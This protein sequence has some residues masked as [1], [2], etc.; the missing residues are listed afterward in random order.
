M[1]AAAAVVLMVGGLARPAQAADPAH[2]D[3]QVVHDGVFAATVISHAGNGALREIALTAELLDWRA[4]HTGA[5]E[6]EV[7]EHAAA[8]RTSVEAKVP[9]DAGV[10]FS[11]AVTAIAALPA[12]AA[13]GPRVNELLVSMTGPDMAAM[14]KTVDQM[15]GGYQHF[16]WATADLS[17]RSR[18]WEQLRRTASAD[19]VLAAAWNAGTGARVGVD[20]TADMEQLLAAEPFAQYVDLDAIK[21]KRGNLDEYLD[22]ITAQ[23]DAVAERVRA[24]TADRLGSTA[25]N[26]AGDIA[27]LAA[28]Y[29][30]A[31]TASVPSQVVASEKE[32]AEQTKKTFDQLASVVKL[33]SG[34]ATIAGGESGKKAAKTIEAVGGALIT[35]GKAINDYGTTVV[36]NGFSAALSSLALTGNV[37]GAVMTLLPLFSGGG[38][39]PE[40][41]TLAQIELLKKQI[42]QLGNEMR[43][44][45][46]RL[47]QQLYTMYTGMSAQL[48]LLQGGIEDVRQRLAVIATDLL[49]LDRR[50]DALSRSVNESL[51]EAAKLPLY[52]AING[53]V[54]HELVYSGPI[55]TAA[56]YNKDAENQIFTFATETAKRPAIVQPMTDVRT[57]GEVL[58]ERSAY[59][60]IAYLRGL[61]GTY[62]YNASIPVEPGGNPTPEIASP[63]MW[64]MAARAYAILQ[65]ENPQYAK[66]VNIH[67]GDILDAGNL[68]NTQARRFSEP[69]ADGATNALFTRLTADYRAAMDAWADALDGVRLAAVKDT[70]EG[71][72]AEQDKNYQLWAGPDQTP[73]NNHTVAE[74]PNMRS[75][76]NTGKVVDIPTS[77]HRAKLPTTL[78][79]DDYVLPQ[80]LAPA[81]RTCYDIGFENFREKEDRYGLSRYADLRVTVHLLVKWAGDSNWSEA[82]TL[83]YA[84][85]VGVVQRVAESAS[86]NYPPEYYFD[87]AWTSRW[88]PALERFASVTDD[89]ATLARARTKTNALLT[90]R[91]KYFFALAATGS[92]TATP[93]ADAPVAVRTLWDRQRQVV[94]TVQL[95]QAYTEVGFA[96]GLLRDDWLRSLLYGYRSL[97][98]DMVLPQRSEPII[99]FKTAYE[100]AYRVY[101]QRCASTSGAP[102]ADDVSG[103]DPQAGQP[104]YTPGCP[105]ASLA[106]RPP[107]PLSACLFVVAQLRSQQLDARY[108]NLSN[109]LRAGTYQEGIPAVS[110]T[111]AFFAAANTNVH[112]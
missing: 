25:D 49:R 58:A 4:R 45:F 111:S 98:V 19:P 6:T 108:S 60:S 101:D 29:P 86:W 80:T 65:L 52:T 23:A 66:L 109:A 5:G 74:S 13:S 39:G 56:E 73:Y 83:T 85:N 71:T 40:A 16:Q 37:L 84:E 112:S 70:T 50:V 35:I 102:C 90:G 107:D 79:F 48:G 67:Q 57:P 33:F 105:D 32:K 21:A 82:R 72:Q 55:E 51:E 42:T 106:H 96:T 12:G 24:L 68:I 75:C 99:H 110:D 69:T 77:A 14:G 92:G 54:H 95:L 100:H 26:E 17:S 88:K 7:R 38:A 1:T 44:R 91:Q 28:A 62:G 87:N 15:R 53:Y 64:N 41:A 27:D 10:D 34:I 78:Q 46:D 2:Y 81:W 8:V 93:P 94:Q 76:A 30:V 43:A 9:A 89:A 63:A 103:I 3:E 20:V 59:D 104:Q 18:T 36:S 31:D 97:P 22:E 11:V 47:D 61:A